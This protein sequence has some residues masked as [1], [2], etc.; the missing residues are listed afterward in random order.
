MNN[1]ITILGPTATGKTTLAA[2]LA[3]IVN[4]EIISAD[5]RQIYC[6][7][8]I[9]TGKDLSDYVVDGKQ[10]PFHLIDIV[11]PGVHYNVFEFLGDF[12]RSFNYVIKAGKLPIMCGGSG[13]Y[14]DAIIRGYKMGKVHTN[15]EL[16]SKL[17]LLSNEE[18]V[19]RLL[20]FGTLHNV[21]D[22]SDKERL[23]RAIEI[24]D[25]QA[26]HSEMILNLPK[27][28]SINFGIHFERDIIRSRITE[29]LEVRL[30]EG[31][32]GEV[33]NL[34]KNGIDPDKLI[35][36]GLEYKF[37]TMFVTGQM[38]YEDMFTKLNTAIHQFAK[39]QMTWYRRMEKNGVKI[40][41]IDGSIDLNDKL[42]VILNQINK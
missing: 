20:A 29:R 19:K 32:I 41:W 36:Y 5:S 23:M 3:L 31:L 11:E 8:D 16:R 7:M 12:T 28:T 4:G 25:F 37:V 40:H 14:L 39:R 15:N 38:S 21:S 22:I 17:D 42:A 24:A 30:H 1:L 27:F 6:G 34:L 33:E 9:G 35:Y 26:K 2:N 13:M 18:L 10:V